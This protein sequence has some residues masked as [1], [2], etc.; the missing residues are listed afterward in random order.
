MLDVSRI[1][2]G[3]LRLD[4]Q[5][6]DLTGVIHAAVDT[7]R[8][9]ADAKEI[10]VSVVLDFGTGVVLGDPVR[11]QQIIW[12]LLSNAIKFTPKRGRIQ[13]Q[14]ERVGSHLETTV[15]DTGPGIDPDFLP[16][17]FER[18]RQAD[19]S[20]SKKHGGLGLGLAIVRHMVEMHGGTVVAANRLDR[21]GAVF[22]VRLPLM[23][24]KPLAGTPEPPRVHPASGKGV[25]FDCP[26]ELAGVRVLAV[27]DEADAR[28][29][30]ATVLKQCG[31]EVKT[32][33]SA[34]E[35]IGLLEEFKPDVLVSDIGMP[36]E[37]GY[38]LIRRI[39][40]WEADRDDG[41]PIPAVAL[42]AY[43]RVEDRVQAL[44]AGY[45]MHVTKPVEPAELAVVIAS[46]APKDRQTPP[47]QG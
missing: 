44:L 29:L 10:R 28:H 26:P 30:L 34:A 46:L 9:A 3:K 35:V 38:S 47:S 22:T 39:R 14:L 7:S 40:A 24:V 19:S 31:A 5:P 2:S 32:C 23:A 41:S 42:T 20:A 8:S 6:V 45:N 27:D 1:V 36:G 17:V 25:T 13:V 4:A 12:N 16:H 33:A 15:S 21:S 43:A 11:L 37:D 18:F